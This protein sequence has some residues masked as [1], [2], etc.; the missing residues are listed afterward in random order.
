M[1]AMFPFFQ[2]PGTLPDCHDLS[3]ISEWLGN[4]ISQF[5]QDSGI[6]LIRSYRLMYVQ[7]PQVVPN[8]AFLFSGKAFALLVPILQSIGSGGPRREFA[9]ED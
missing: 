4:G 2:S 1:G 3:N 5:P 6:H 7:V 8:L 9:S